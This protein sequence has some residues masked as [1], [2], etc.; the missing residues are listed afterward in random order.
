[1]PGFHSFLRTGQHCPEQPAPFSFLRAV[2]MTAAQRRW[3]DRAPCSMGTSSACRAVPQRPF[4]LAGNLVL[5]TSSRRAAQPQTGQQGALPALTADSQSCVVRGSFRNTQK[6]HRNRRPRG[7][8]Q[9]AD[10][11]C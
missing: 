11:K 7:L 8:L 9:G 6:L 1:M 5:T 4:P 3:S 10:C 2:A